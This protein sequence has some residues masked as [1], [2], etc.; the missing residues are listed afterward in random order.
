M[1][2]YDL[3][4]AIKLIDGNWY[5]FAYRDN[6]VY[7]IGNDRPKDGG[8]WFARCNDG[9]IRYVATPSPTRKSAWAKAHR[10]GTYTGE[11]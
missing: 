10:H 4:T 9:G 2:E 7:S 11:W 6:E 5:A 1:L 3:K 8:Y